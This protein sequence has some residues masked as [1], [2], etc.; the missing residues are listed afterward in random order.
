MINQNQ[1]QKKA[2]EVTLRLSSDMIGNANDET[3][4]SLC[5]VCENN[6]SYHIKLWKAQISKLIQSS[7][8]LGKLPGPSMKTGLPL[9]KN[10]LTLLRK[11]IITSLG[12]TRGSSAVH[13]RIKNKIVG[14]GS[15]D[16]KVFL[17]FFRRV[18]FLV[19]YWQIMYI[20]R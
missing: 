12:L 7:R 1:Q 3:L 20:N 11:S 17:K 9:M 18:D 14:P 13:T 5:K 8:F 6:S 4:S 15:S 10:V 16:P 19:C 2:T